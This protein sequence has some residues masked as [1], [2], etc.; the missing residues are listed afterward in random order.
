MEIQKLNV[1]NGL[2]Q[3]ILP[4]IYSNALSYEEQICLIGSVVDSIIDVFNGTIEEQLKEYIEK[5]FN[6]MMLNAM[7]DPETET[8]SLYLNKGV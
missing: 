4:T 2:H 5:E 7:Y 3:K 1:C 6:K 8:L